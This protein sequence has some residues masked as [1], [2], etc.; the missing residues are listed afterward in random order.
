MD[1][2]VESDSI[3]KSLPKRKVGR[4]RIRKN[5][6]DAQRAYRQKQKIKAARAIRQAGQ[7]K[8]VPLDQLKANELVAQ[9]HR[10][11]KPLRVTKLNIGASKDGK[12]VGAAMCMRPAC[13][14][15]EDGLTL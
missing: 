9:W 4:P 2:Q 14:S 1:N 11:H 15:L 5:H 6:A 12:L 10:H 3:I 7:L 8:V 13:H